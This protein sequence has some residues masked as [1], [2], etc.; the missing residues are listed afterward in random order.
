MA[1]KCSTCQHVKRAEIDRRLAAGERGNQIAADYDLNPSSLHRHRTNCLNLASSNA[2]M[3]EVSRG[4]AAVACLPGKDD[5][6][7]AYFDLRGRIDQI[8]DQAQA[9]GS[10]QIALSGL[11]SIRQTLDSL[12][13][14]AGFDRQGTQVNVAVRTNV[15]LGI[16][17]IADRLI[18]KFDREPEL[19]ARIAQPNNVGW[20]LTGFDGPLFGHPLIEAVRAAN[21]PVAYLDWSRGAVD[22]RA[23]D[24]AIDPELQPDRLVDQVVAWIEGT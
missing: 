17:Q 16:T 18:L 2:I 1:R 21:V 15:N 12:S 13:R 7:A 4:T 24:L 10:L 14:L 3:K 19:K 22:Q 23:R 9:Q 11:N 20:M 6:G 8:V 5:L